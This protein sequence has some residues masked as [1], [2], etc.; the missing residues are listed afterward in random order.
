MA[1]CWWKLLLEVV[2]KPMSVA[3]ESVVSARRQKPKKPKKPAVAPV[4][5]SRK[6]IHPTSLTAVPSR[7]RSR[8]V[9]RL[10]NYGQKPG[11]LRSLL[12]AQLGSKLA[13]FVLIAATLAIY[14]GT[15][16][17]QQMWSRQYRKLENLQ[18]Q[19]RQMTAANEVLKN[20][21]AQQAENPDTGLVAPTPD[22]RIFLQPAPQGRAEIANR[23]VRSAPEPAPTAP[24]GY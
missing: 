3:R 2:V 11:W 10:P 20:Q 5:T 12:A 23:T 14:A 7:T 4:P 21:L 1:D 22:N 15:V 16:Y 18:R 8:Q 17:T 9:E 6:A 24:L 19:E 13:T